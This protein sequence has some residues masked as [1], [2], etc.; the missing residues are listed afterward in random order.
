MPR[1]RAIAAV[2]LGGLLSCAPGESGEAAPSATRPAAPTGLAAQGGDGRVALTW[3]ASAGASSYRLK[4]GTSAGTYGASWTTAGTA[5]VD[6]AV[7]NGTTYHY[8]VTAIGAAGESGDSDEAV[9]TPSAGPSDP[10]AGV[11]CSGHGTCEATGAAA[12]CRCSEHFHAVGLACVADGACP[13]TTPAETFGASDAPREV[14]GGFTTPW[15]YDR[16]ANA[17]RRYPLVVNGCWD[18]SGYFD[19]AVRRTYPAFYAKVGCGGEGDG[20]ALAAS[21][22]SALAAGLRIDTDRIYLTGFSQ[23]GSGSYKLIRGFYGGA[24]RRLF[25]GLV[26]V[27]GASESILAEA[28]VGKTSIWYHIGLTDDAGRVAVAREAYAYLKSHAAN[29]TAV[30]TTHVDTV[31][32]GQA[33]SR[34]TKVLTKDGIAVVKLSEIANWGHDPAAAYA[35]R[36]VFDWLFAQSLACR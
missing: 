18:E 17:A 3:S 4:R 26:R 24:Q 34:T 36:T 11:T 32:V 15:G 14:A 21:V 20:V 2:L 27:A 31:T 23:G 30:E 22:E 28:A 25:A 1:V 12:V 19:D 8:V 16:A 13:L 6:T 33:Y 7:V 5:H 35:D 10:C 29:A 9:A